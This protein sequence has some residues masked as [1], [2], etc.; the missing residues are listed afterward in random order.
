MTPSSRERIAV[1]LFNLGGPDSLKS[2]R[3]FLYNLFNDPMIMRVPGWLR[4][5][6]AWAIS[7]KRAPKTREI[8]RK[9]GDKSP[10][11]EITEKQAAAVEN[12]LIV[13]GD[14][15][16]KVFVSMRYWHP[17]AQET[18]EA[19]KAYNPTRVVLLPLYPQYSTTTTASSFKEWEEV[20][21][22]AGLVVP[23]ARVCCYPTQ[24]HFIAAHINLLREAYWKASEDA[25]PR[26]LFSAHGLPEKIVAEGDPYQKQV[27]ATV[28]AITTVF[29]MP[30]M[31]Y[32]VCY[33]SKVGPLKWIGP[34]TEDE[35]RR[36]GEEKVPLVVVPVA[37]VSEHSETLVELDVDYKELAEEHGVPSY[38]R[39]PALGMEPLFIEAL[40]AL[41]Q[42]AAMRGSGTA[43]EGGGDACGGQC[44][45]CACERMDGV[46]SQMVAA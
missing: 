29:S 3:P 39:V 21:A 25:K 7:T 5:P 41:A 13:R 35:I 11:L 19:V 12:S 26:V 16:Y 2:V 6:L 45:G 40:A 33:Q 15:D 22:A 23:T 24:V 10:L 34:S 31:D 38:V 43:S 44:A 32:S 9:I 28:R 27:E 8:Y 42:E 30:D 1:V 20:A 17:L 14:H 36:A 46:L 18:V 37:F 4:S